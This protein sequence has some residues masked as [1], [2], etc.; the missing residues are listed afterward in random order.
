[1]NHSINIT[2]SNMISNLRTKKS[3][4]V[5]WKTRKKA[6][7]CIKKTLAIFTCNLHLNG[8]HT[9]IRSFYPHKFSYLQSSVVICFLYT[10]YGTL[11]HGWS[12]T[13]IYSIYTIRIL[14]YKNYSWRNVPVTLPRFLAK[15]EIAVILRELTQLHTPEYESYSTHRC[16]WTYLYCTNHYTAIIINFI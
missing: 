5:S 6:T 13:A 10:S 2:S 9:S 16:V 7:F 3:Y 11:T 14:P 4:P 1:M 15:F 8:P 12:H